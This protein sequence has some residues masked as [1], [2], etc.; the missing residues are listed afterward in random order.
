MAGPDQLVA[1]LLETATRSDDPAELVNLA[2]TACALGRAAVAIQP[3]HPDL[4]PTV[5]AVS[6]VWLRDRGLARLRHALLAGPGRRP[7]LSPQPDHA[8]VPTG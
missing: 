8:L 7:A 5:R 4:D 1:T 2:C 6:F 3:R